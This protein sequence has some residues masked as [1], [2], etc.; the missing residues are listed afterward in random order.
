MSVPLPY[1]TT[2]H[3][4]IMITLQPFS[5][6]FELSEEF[7]LEDYLEYCKDY[8]I[9]PSQKHYKEWA[10]ECVVNCLTDD[11]D[12][13]RF[14][15]IY[16]D[17]QEIDLNTKKEETKAKSF[18]YEDH[19]S[20]LSEEEL[21]EFNKRCDEGRISINAH[22]YYRDDSIII[23]NTCEDNADAYGIIHKNGQILTMKKSK[24]DYFL[25]CYLKQLKETN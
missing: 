25:F 12:I 2:V 1:D 11:I 8:G 14:V 18:S 4:N 5:I 3:K 10:T 17:P 20:D 24:N 13:D 15:Y 23:M 21:E 9:N 6:R 7:P 22:P 19:V 16:D